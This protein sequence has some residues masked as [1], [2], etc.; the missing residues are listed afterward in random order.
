MATFIGTAGEFQKERAI[1]R[2]LNALMGVFLLFAAIFFF[3]GFITAQRS[4]LWSLLA[5]VVVVPGFKLFERL[6]DQQIRYPN[7]RPDITF[8]G[9]IVPLHGVRTVRPPDVI[10]V[11]HVICPML[12]YTHGRRSISGR[13]VIEMDSSLKKELRRALISAELTMKDWLIRC[14]ESFISSLQ[15]SQAANSPS[16]TRSKAR[17][18]ALD[19]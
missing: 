4:I 3:I 2:R 13:V 17:N 16:S 7:A 8:M 11:L 19:G 10:C 9:I 18:G 14:A 5:V 15:V 1:N 12:H 6:F